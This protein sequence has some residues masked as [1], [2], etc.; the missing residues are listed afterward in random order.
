VAWPALRT[1]VR[2]R[3]TLDGLDSDRHPTRRVR[4]P[5]RRDRQY[6]SPWGL[7]SIYARLGETGFALE[8]LERAYDE[9]DSTLVWLK[10]H[11]RFD[12]LRAEPHF[13]E[14][15]KKMGLA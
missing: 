2:R 13:I 11:P 8:W 10:V 12:A 14:I 6:V 4:D 3:H 9:H 1:A 15:L 5:R 7:A